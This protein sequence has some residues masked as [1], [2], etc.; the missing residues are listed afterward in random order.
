[1]TELAP[2]DNF[3]FLVEQRQLA[4]QALLGLVPQHP[5]FVTYGS[6]WPSVL[7]RH[8]VRK[9]DVGRLV[10]ELRKDGTLS[11]DNWTAR[12]RV[13]DDSFRLSRAAV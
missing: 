4:K 2:D 13:P 11:V 6:V 10:A 3:Q 9:T 7:A 1:M 12:K 8:A 5:S